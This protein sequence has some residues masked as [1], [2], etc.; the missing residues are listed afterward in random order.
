MGN[1]TE[2]YESFAKIF[3][4]KIAIHTDHQQI[5]YKNWSELVNQ[6]ANWLNS[7][8]SEN[9]IIGIHLPNGI[10]FLQLFAGAAKAGW[11]AVPLDL[12]W[13]TIELEERVKICNPSIIVT[14]KEIYY[15]NK[16]II[17]NLKSLDDILQEILKF[18]VNIIRDTQE[19]LPFYIGFTSGTTGKPKAFVRSQNSWLASFECNRIDFKLNELDHVFI[20]G[21]LI[22]SHFLYGAISTLYLGGTVYLLDKF[23]PIKGHL[24]IQSYPITTMYVVPTMLEAFQKQGILINEPIKVLS[25]GA[26]WSERLKL[27]IRNHFPNMTMYEFYGASELSFITVLSERDG[28][29]K[30]ESV[31]KPCSGVE[32][33]IRLKDQSL[34]RPNEIGKVYVRSGLI[35]T[36]YMDSDGRTVHSIR[37][38]EGW[39]TVHDMGYFDEDGYLYITG[40]EQNM[41]LYGGINIFPEEIEKVISMHPDVEEV[42]VIGLPDS[43]WGQVVTAVVKGKGSSLELKR[44]CNK[45]LSS[46][47]IPRKW[48]FLSE[49]PYTTSGKIARAELIKQLERKVTSN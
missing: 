7:L 45:Y 31:G 47:K 12:K 13:K 46:Y 49:M 4:N 21:A 43:Y 39:A 35:I 40:R 2:S 19:D 36:G 48:F 9:K 37:D 44:L 25:S 3:P 38:E 26:K 17:P 15:R 20:P 16:H 30:A 34:A 6:T 29:K 23:S 11:I 22:H 42:A 41:I 1:I 10:P 5:N 33:Q 8:H 32:V 27:E 24:W 14:T 18:E 28:I